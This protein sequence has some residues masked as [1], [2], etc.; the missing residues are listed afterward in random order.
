MS[1]Y[2]KRSSCLML[3][4]SRWHIYIC[5]FVSMF[6][7]LKGCLSCRLTKKESERAIG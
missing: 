7:E 2:E 6:K 4:E 5:L 3:R 1:E